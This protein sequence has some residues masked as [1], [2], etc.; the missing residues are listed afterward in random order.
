MANKRFLDTT[1]ETDF[2][3]SFVRGNLTA[4]E[5]KDDKEKATT[6]SKRRES[7]KA[8]AEGS[9][10]AKDADK[11]DTKTVKQVKI[12]DTSGSICSKFLAESNKDKDKDKSKG[13]K[14]KCKKKTI[15][16]EE[17]YTD[18]DRAAAVNLGTRDI[19]QSLK[20]KRAQDRSRALHIPEEA[21]PAQF[22]ALGYYE[23]KK[24]ETQIALNFI[25]KVMNTNIRLFIIRWRFLKL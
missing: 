13:A 21:D 3:Q 17:L 18:K 14:K 15:K 24:H 16:S 20:L 22:L 2:L 4:Q 6:A 25:N 12:V 10:L 19:K 7:T 8:G 23:L 11:S 1:M 5:T 9:D